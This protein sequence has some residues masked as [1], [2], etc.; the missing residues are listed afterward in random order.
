MKRSRSA[1]TKGVAGRSEQDIG[2]FS[3]P[4]HYKFPTC[5]LFPACPGVIWDNSKKRSP[6]A[7]G[8]REAP[9]LHGAA[10]TPGVITARS[11]E[12]RGGRLRGPDLAGQ[13]DHEVELGPLGVGGD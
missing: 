10:R 12:V 3:V 2:N 11:G 7:E 9:R 4:E 8:V 13:A 5:Q 1:A 6:A